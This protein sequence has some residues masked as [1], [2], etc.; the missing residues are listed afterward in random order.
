MTIALL[1]STVV[2]CIM[3][4]FLGFLMLGVFRSMEILRWEMQ[5][6]QATTPR[7]LGRSGLNPGKK[8]P[9][10]K[11]PTV[12]GTEVTLSAHA[13]RKVFLVFVQT[14][15]GPCG[16]VVPD[17]NR[18][19]R[20]G[21]YQLLVVNNADLD[22]ARKWLNDVNAEFPVLLQEGWKVSKRYQVMATPFAFV[23]DEKGVITSKGIVNS[24]R[25]IGFVLDGR[26]DGAEAEHGEEEAGAKD[27]VESNGSES[28][29]HA[30]EVS[31]VG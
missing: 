16:A 22:K 1:V 3:F 4:L 31:H 21:K 18:M 7:R 14:G 12:T 11:L 23:I 17:L 29:V 30:K 8:A 15:C 28:T 24:S 10:F 2:L 6:L 5:Q 13:G 27:R 25:Q 19:H 9:D 26:K 20:E